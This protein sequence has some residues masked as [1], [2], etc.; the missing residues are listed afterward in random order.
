MYNRARLTVRRLSQAVLAGALAIIVGL[1]GDQPAYAQDEPPP[2][3][4]SW[5]D[6]ANLL[7]MSLL[8]ASEDAGAA[9]EEMKVAR[10]YFETHEQV[11][12]LVA[13]LDV[14]EEATTGG[15]VTA[16]V[17][18]ADR[19]RLRDAGYRFEIDEAKTAEIA[20]AS[21][22]VAAA[23]QASGAEAI[24]TIPGYSCY[25]TVEETYTSLATLAANNPNLATWTDIGNSWEKV[26]PGG[27]AGFDIFALVLTNKL[28]PGPKPKFFLMSAIHAREYTTAELATRFAEELVAKYNVD[29]DVTWMLD[30]YEFHLVPQ[31]NPDGRKLAEGG[32]LWRKNTDSDDGCRRSTQWGTDLNRN[33]SFKWNTG[34]SSG[35]AC[36]ETYRGPGAASEPETQAVETYA[37]LIFPDQRGPADTDAAPATTEGVFISLHS[38]SELVLF[39]W[40]WTTTPAPNSTALQT[41]GRKF[42]YLTGY[43]VCNGPTCLYATSG[44]TDDYTYGKL[45]VA[46][47]TFELGTA[48][49]Q[50]CSTF[51]SNIIPKNM[52][53]LYYALKS[54]RRPYQTPAG[55]DT[56]GVAVSTGSVNAGTPVNL[57]ATANDTRYNS[58]GWG[59]E[60]TQAIQAARYSID[61][62]SWLATTVPMAAADGSFNTTVENVAATVDTTGLASG[63]HILFV[64]AQDAAGN[65]GP[66]TAVFLTIN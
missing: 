47:Y 11:H 64:E 56:L 54:A 17:S 50:S 51:T 63:R 44:T 31:V 28:K 18:A 30:N 7:F 23:L 4:E 61:Q 20:D 10:I 5:L 57:T 9:E 8:N 42:G 6:A 62:P 39:P 52:P 19:V 45:G 32:Q 40:G 49:F 66:P 1:A 29:A 15:Y 58:N 21:A 65:W 55:P 22:V 48:F 25:R 33:S 53:A 41:L 43:Q 27:K 12:D 24:D 34:G 38:Y 14:F 37:T 13:M 60:A 46:S 35:K 36:N 26:I 59:T 16:Y 2:A 3:P